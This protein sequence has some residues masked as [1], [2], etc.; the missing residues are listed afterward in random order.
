MT[1]LI[2]GGTA[3]ARE[4]AAALARSGQD[5][6]TSLAG[7]I[8]NPALPLGGVRVGSFGGIEGLIGYLSTAGVSAIVDA[9]HPFAAQISENAAAA[10]ERTGIP[11]IRLERPSW[12]DHPR[13][14]TWSWVPD[15]AAARAAGQNAGRPFLTSGRQSLDAFL[16]WG[17]RSVLVRLVE[18]PDR[19]LPA[20]WTVLI[21]RGPY[22]YAG[23]RKIMIDHSIDLLIT[24]DSGGSHTAA[25]L[26]A[27]GDLGID[28]VIIARPP[29]ASAPHVV[30]VAEAM[31]W[32]AGAPPPHAA[33]VPPSS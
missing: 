1:I 28:V 26:D 23:E 7:R 17:D 10:A 3:E 11:L 2:L 15:A 19:S 9:T 13:A 31:A 25:K 16:A 12:A 5:V 21:S 18:L 32:F 14:G 29:R 8:R 22:S 24:K 27:A 33:A 30:G 4:L 6:V 20:S